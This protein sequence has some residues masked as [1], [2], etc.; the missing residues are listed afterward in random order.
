M[1]LIENTLDYSV[2][3]S[4]YSGRTSYS[5]TYSTQTGNISKYNIYGSGMSGTISP[6]Y[7]GFG[8]TTNKEISLKISNAVKYYN[9][10]EYDYHTGGALYITIKEMVAYTKISIH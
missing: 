9:K 3:S 2:G 1:S 10:V 8:R 6:V 5:Y 7:D 4:A